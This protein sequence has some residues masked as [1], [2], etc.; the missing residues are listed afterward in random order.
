M[1]ANMEMLRKTGV[2]I[3]EY[4]GSRDVMAPAGSCVAA[5]AWGQ[6][7]AA[8]GL[9][10]RLRNRSIEENVGHIFLGSRRRLA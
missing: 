6:T 10:G 2:A 4:K 1:P 8:S 9:K 3:F 7:G 5:E